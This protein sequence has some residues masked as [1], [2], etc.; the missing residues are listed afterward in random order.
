MEL[1]TDFLHNYKHSLEGVHPVVK[2]MATITLAFIL[3][4]VVSAVINVLA[5]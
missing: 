1:F 3:V 5:S 2:I 4:A